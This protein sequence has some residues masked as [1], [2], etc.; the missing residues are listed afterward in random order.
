MLS[1]GKTSSPESPNGGDLQHQLPPRRNSGLK[2]F[3]V[4]LKNMVFNDDKDRGKT[5]VTA[6]LIGKGGGGRGRILIGIVMATGN[7]RQS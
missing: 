4:K 2:A 6:Y 1:P 7:F 5:H 3:T